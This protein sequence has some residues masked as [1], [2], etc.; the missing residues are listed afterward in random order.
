VLTLEEQRLAASIRRKKTAP[1]LPVNPVGY[2]EIPAV[3]NDYLGIAAE[4]N[5]APPVV[6]VPVSDAI[7]PESS[8]GEI[9]RQ[10][11]LDEDITIEEI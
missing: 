5:Q 6:N 2:V 9:V 11:L 7:L 1:Q 8:L 10:Q 4:L 3:I